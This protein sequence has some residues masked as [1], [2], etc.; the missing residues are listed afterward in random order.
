[1]ERTCIFIELLNLL[2]VPYTDDYS[3]RRFISMPFKSLFGFT[4]LLKEYGIDSEG[5]KL[6]DKND[7]DKLP[8]PSLVQLGG[9]FVIMTSVSADSVTVLDEGVY[10]TLSKSDFID[11]WSGIVIVVYPQ[12]GAKEPHF[13]SHRNALIADKAKK[14][15]WIAS[16]ALLFCYLFISNGIYRHVSTVLLTLFNGFGLYIT[17]LLVLKQLSI[18]S[19]AADKV[20]GVL[21]EGGC[22]TVLE[23]KASKFFG[24][25][26]WSEVGFSYFGVNL[27]TLLIFPQ[28][29]NY[30]AWFNVCCLPFTV[31]SIWYQHFRAHAWC[32]LCVTVQ[33]TL[34]LLFFCNLFG[35][36]LYGLFPLRV[37][38]FV[39]G[40][41]YLCALLSLNRLLPMFDRSEPDDGTP[42]ADP[43]K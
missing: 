27:L 12:P 42:S 25:F 6:D 1:M 10:K 23:Q 17:Y 24:L 36:W 11:K 32:T 40:V 8:V 3:H 20:C 18:H 15:V 28:F 14:W 31:W 38:I 30:L 41:T 16:I 22:N 2:E 39:L 4:K 5:L 37:E 13:K 34:W 43:I 26:G 7:V 29:T 35:G 21:Q 9:R 33:C 19:K